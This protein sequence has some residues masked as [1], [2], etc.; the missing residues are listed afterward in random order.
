MDY[1]TFTHMRAAII[2]LAV[3][4]G[5]AV[6]FLISKIEE[7]RLS[8]NLLEAQDEE[9]E[10]ITILMR[11]EGVFVPRKNMKEVLDSK[12]HLLMVHGYRTAVNRLQAKEER[13]ALVQNVQ[14]L[15]LKVLH[16][17]KQEQK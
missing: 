3:A 1:S 11:K 8:R 5:F 12:D 13:E 4:L 15:W 7:A 6:F 2:L 10:A 14:A 16:K 17:R 9:I